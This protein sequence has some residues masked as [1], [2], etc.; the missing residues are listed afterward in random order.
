MLGSSLGFIVFSR[1]ASFD[2]VV[3]MTLTWA[4][5]FFIA[6]EICKQRQTTAETAGRFL[7]LHRSFV[8]RQ[9]TNWIGNTAGDRGR[10]LCPAP[11][12]AREIIVDQFVVGT[13]AE[14]PGSGNLVWTDAGKTRWTLC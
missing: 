9:R 7:C 6:S 5:A 13:P 10:L 1:A 14:F 3:T 8:A 12:V 4:L 11:K 2:V